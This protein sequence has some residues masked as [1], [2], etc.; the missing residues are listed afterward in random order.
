MIGLFYRKKREG[1]NS[2]ETVFSAID[3]DLLLHKNIC[4]PYEGASPIKIL[5]NIVFAF[6]HRVEVNHITGDAHY[7]AIGLGR[8]TILTIHDVQS[9]L[10]INNPLKRFYVKLLWF[11]I[12]AL[13]VKKIT[14]I[15]EFTRKEL[16]R[17]IPFAKNKIVVVH[18]PFCSDLQ[19]SFTKNNNDKPI[20]LHLGTKSN[21]NL[22]RV[23]EAVKNINCKLV[24]LGKMTSSQHELMRKFNVNYEEYFDLPYGK[25]IELYQHCNVV[26]FPSLYEGF[27]LPILEANVI[28][29]PVLAGDIEVLHEV[30]GEAA[31]FVNPKDTNAIKSGFVELLN[32]S[33]LQN[34]LVKK[35]FDNVRRFNPQYIASKYNK[36]YIQLKH[37]KNAI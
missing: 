23:A 12:P 19:F 27:G 28:G 22:E 1:V 33:D 10:R 30:A 24:V 2:M 5:R 25:V 17:I 29:R 31:Y 13:I 37:K 26:S 34:R 8:N 21:K 15:S 14:V 11:Y 6:R 3:K 7:I 18:N 16:I 4:I 20:I 36:L 32:D 35:G 9:A